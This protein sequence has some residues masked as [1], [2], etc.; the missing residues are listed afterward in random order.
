MINIKDKIIERVNDIQDPQL[1]E[2]LLH[3]IELE[4]EIEHFHVLT[5]EEK[6]AID[7]GIKDADAGNMF[8]N[9]EATQLVKK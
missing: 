8:S 3:A 9:L 1:L 7:E 6:V 2:E 4:H 5:N